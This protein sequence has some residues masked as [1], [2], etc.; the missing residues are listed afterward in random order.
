MGRSC[1]RAGQQGVGGTLRILEGEENA[2]VLYFEG[3]VT[4][5]KSC[6]MLW[7]RE[8]GRT[9]CQVLRKKRDRDCRFPGYTEELHGRKLS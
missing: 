8:C 4:W 6:A 1:F 9:V 2:A 7:H 3:H 5:D